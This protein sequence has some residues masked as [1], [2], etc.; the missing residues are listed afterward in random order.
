VRKRLMAVGGRKRVSR[1]AIYA[2]NGMAD[3]LSQQAV[4]SIFMADGGYRWPEPRTCG[5]G[6][7][8]IDQAK[9]RRILSVIV[10]S[11]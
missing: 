7:L 1:A 4:L 11:A 10:R 9:V 3:S 6:A 2:K 5:A 8:D